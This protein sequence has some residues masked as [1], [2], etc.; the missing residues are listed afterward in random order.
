VT[1][2]VDVGSDSD[3][4][5]AYT[6]SIFKVEISMC[7]ECIYIYILSVQKTGGNRME[8]FGDLMVAPVA[9]S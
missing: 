5:D 9:C 2:D 3:V 6:V 1:C 4:L 7:S 8:A